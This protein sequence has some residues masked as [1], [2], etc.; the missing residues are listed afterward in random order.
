MRSHTGKIAHLTNRAHMS[1]EMAKVR[2]ATQLRGKRTT[3]YDL[4]DRGS[5]L[6]R[7][8]GTLASLQ[9]CSSC[10]LSSDVKIQPVTNTAGPHRVAM[11]SDRQDW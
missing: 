9:A 10:S 6:S 11:E 2:A 5:L 8:T 3:R 4:E 7:I 1:L